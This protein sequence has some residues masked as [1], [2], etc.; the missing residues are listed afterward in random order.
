MLENRY[1][2]S[3]PDIDTMLLRSFMAV[4]DSGNFSRAAERIGRTQSA[5][6]QQIKKLE[7]VCDKTFFDRRAKRIVLTADGEWFLE[8][9]EQI[10][11]IRQDIFTK[12]YEEDIEGEVRFGVPE[13]FATAYL[14]N[15]LSDF[16]K[17]H[18]SQ[19]IWAMIFVPGFFA[20]W[21]AWR[22]QRT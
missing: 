6:S 17:A 20:L 7:E 4:A 9:A 22:A 5:V 15:I 1:K 19:I 3:F 14:S 16:V 18:L 10:I 11:K 2:D 13:D 12:F 21:G 8:K